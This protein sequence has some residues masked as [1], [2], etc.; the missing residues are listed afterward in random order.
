VDT[1]QVIDV[2]IADFAVAKGAYVLESRGIGSCV[3]VCFYDSDQKLGALCHIMLPTHP[4]GS[5]LN[6]LRFADTAIPLVLDELARMGSHRQHLV[7]HLIG[8]AS[9]FQDL[10]EFVNKIGNQNII[11]VKQILEQQGLPI[12]STDVGGNAG[13]SVSFFLDNG[14]VSITG[15]V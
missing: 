10:G 3:V 7:T 5:G 12:E 14:S 15:R 13:R 4:E 1:Q 2:G 8:G 9:M 6:P 11:A